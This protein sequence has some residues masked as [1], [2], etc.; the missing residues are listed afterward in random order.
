MVLFVAFQ[1]LETYVSDSVIR[2][3]VSS[4]ILMGGIPFTGS[5][6]M[7]LTGVGVAMECM[8]TTNLVRI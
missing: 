5:E 4:F 7:V 1:G 3:F 2:K 8:V 6:E